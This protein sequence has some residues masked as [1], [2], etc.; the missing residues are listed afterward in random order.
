MKRESEEKQSQKRFSSDRRIFDNGNFSVKNF[1][2]SENCAV[3]ELF[4]LQFFHLFVQTTCFASMKKFLPEILIDG[5]NLICALGILPA[6]SSRQPLSDGKLAEGR[7]ALL[8]LLANDLSEEQRRRTTVVFDAPKLSKINCDSF[9]SRGIQVL[10]AQNFNTADDLIIEMILAQ[11]RE[12]DWVVVSS[13]RRIQNAA[14]RRKMKYFDSAD[15]F[16][17][18]MAEPVPVKPKP[19]QKSDSKPD[20]KPGELSREELSYWLKIFEDDTD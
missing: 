14:R 15:W 4:V 8:K 2:G 13:D 12:A 20:E 17:D 3:F 16:Y 6:L 5:Y 1:S 19:D 7:D 10:F 11:K 9:R 18:V